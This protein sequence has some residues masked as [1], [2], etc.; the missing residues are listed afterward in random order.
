LRHRARWPGVHAGN[1][2]E[3]VVTVALVREHGGSRHGCLHLRRRGHSGPGLDGHRPLR[4]DRRLNRS[5]QRVAARAG[6]NPGLCGPCWLRDVRRLD[7]SRR[8]GEWRRLGASRWLGQLRRPSGSGRLDRPAPFRRIPRCRRRGPGCLDRRRTRQGHS[9]RLRLCCFRLGRWR[10]R[11]RL[12]RRRRSGIFLRTRSRRLRLG[13]ACLRC[14]QRLGTAPGFGHRRSGLG[15]RRRR[16]PR[17]RRRVPYTGRGK[18]Q[19]RLPRR[20]AQIPQQEGPMRHR[21]HDQQPDD[22]GIDPRWHGDSQHAPSRPVPTLLAHRWP[23][24]QRCRRRR[25][26]MSVA[27]LRLRGLRDARRQ[28]LAGAMPAVLRGIPVERLTGIADAR[29]LVRWNGGAGR[30]P[31]GP[32]GLRCRC[33]RQRRRIQVHRLVGGRRGRVFEARRAGRRLAH[34]CDR[35]AGLVSHGRGPEV[36]T[37]TATS[38]HRVPSRRPAN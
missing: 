15:R 14:L 33:R 29:Q 38:R 34:A 1:F 21:Q 20:A 4:G 26:P 24:I 37:A 10:S 11:G 27:R 9:G 30:L 2:A 12:D 35:S 32:V 36:G 19:R 25:P 5:G 8:L 13:R 6:L 16:S 17:L 31:T 7:A 28:Q 18:R 23:L 3:W 22:G